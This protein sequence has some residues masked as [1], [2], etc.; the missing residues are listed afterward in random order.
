MTNLVCWKPDITL[1]TK[2]HIVKVMVF[3]A[4]L[5]GCENWTFKKAECQRIDALDLWCWRKL[6]KVP[7]TARRSNQSILNEIKPE[8]S[9]E[10]LML[11]LKLKYFGHLMWTDDSLESLWCWERLRTEG[12][13]HQRMRGL[14][15]I[16]DAMNM[17]LGKFQEMVRNREAGRATVHGVAKRLTWLGDWKTTTVLTLTYTHTYTK[18]FKTGDTDS[19]SQ[20]KA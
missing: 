15:G 9:L 20:S 4:V 8:Y 12:E 6:L 2:V 11:K 3:P 18:N 10:E 13:E 7:C 1:P 14:D 17:N 16:I 19:Y 5:Y